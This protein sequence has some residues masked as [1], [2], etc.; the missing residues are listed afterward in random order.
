MKMARFV[1]ISEV[2]AIAASWLNPFSECGKLF[3]PLPSSPPGIYI[4][5][6][7]ESREFVRAWGGAGGGGVIRGEE[8][9]LVNGI[10]K[11]LPKYGEMNERA[12]IRNNSNEAQS[13]VV[14]NYAREK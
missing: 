3:C 7:L 8:S 11:R 12:T 13:V 6:I 14:V 1:M 9:E 10:E 2:D 5:R 4:F